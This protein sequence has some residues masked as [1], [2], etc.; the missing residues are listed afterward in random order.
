[1]RKRAGS[2]AA[3]VL[4]GLLLSLVPISSDAMS[5]EITLSTGSGQLVGT[6]EIPQPAPGPLPVVLIVPS[7]GPTDRDGNDPQG[8]STNTYRMLADALALNGIASVRYDK[9]GI[10]ESRDALQS[11]PTYAMFVDDVSAWVHALRSDSRLSTVVLAGVDDG[12]QV[13]LLAAA[14]AH[15]D[16]VIS[17]AGAGR[18]VGERLLS[19]IRAQ[20]PSEAYLLRFAQVAIADLRAGRSPPNLPPELA[21]LFTPAL[22][23]YWSQVLNVDPAAAA[24]AAKA[25]LAILQGD[26]DVEVSVQDAKRLAQAR[27]DAS[28]SILPHMT[29]TLKDAS[30]D[31]RAAS[32]ATYNNPTLPIDQGV[33]HAVVAFVR[34]LRPNP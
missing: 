15:V 32:L 23:T 19:Q 4:L 25:P 21:S 28:L 3:F 24:R 26:A 10:G 6:M 34:G 13:A 5:T 31:T 22:N 30:A 12:S 18:P 7:S 11:A 33:V 14:Q 27:P 2:A 29:H 8:A 1:M 9:R 17:I 16:G 20:G